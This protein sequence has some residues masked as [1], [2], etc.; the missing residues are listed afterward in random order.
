M[1][2]LPTVEKPAGEYAGSGV[3]KARTLTQTVCPASV[4]TLADAQR[5][6]C[7]FAVPDQQVPVT[8]GRDFALAEKAL[9]NSWIDARYI[10]TTDD[11]HDLDGDGD[12][13]SVTLG[14]DRSISD[15]GNLVAGAMLSLMQGHSSSFSD[16]LQTEND[17]IAIGPYFGYRLAN[18]WSLDA[19]LL[20]GRS[21][22]GLEIA[23]AQGDYSADQ[24]TASS[25]L[26][27]QY[28]I[29]DT[30]L[31]PKFTLNYSHI[32]NDAYDISANILG[33]TLSWDVDDDRID[34]ALA[35]SVLEINRIVRLENEKVFVPYVELGARYDIQQANDGEIVGGD[36]QVESTSRWTGT[37]RLGG[38]YYVSQTTYLEAGA[39]YLSFAQSGLD[40]WEGRFY[41]SH[42]F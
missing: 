30:Y 15:S 8:P 42:L 29:G 26:T 19:S 6:D 24:Y 37:L 35:E 32:R 41:L 25:T 22:T 17:A 21:D 39:G 18:N 20:Y 38:R 13:N 4:N 3:E 33:Q 14:A 28:G 7:L 9:W 11:R 23:E 1:P 2:E 36:L 40:V 12:G 34:L 27:G 31:R 10:N 16:T 5:L